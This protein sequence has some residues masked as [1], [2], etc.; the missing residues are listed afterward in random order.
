MGPSAALSV[1]VADECPTG[2]G[3]SLFKPNPG[4]EAARRPGAPPPVAVRRASDGD[5]RG[6]ELW[7]SPRRCLRG[8]LP[9]EWGK[10]SGVSDRNSRRRA[11][12]DGAPLTVPGDD[13]V[14]KWRG[15]EDP[16]T[17]RRSKMCH[18]RSDL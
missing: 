12:D 9:T 4:L 15:E 8:V 10:N 6:N 3:A 13:E 11:A 5:E 16:A 14:G 1:C 2:V 7:M 17:R 18:Y